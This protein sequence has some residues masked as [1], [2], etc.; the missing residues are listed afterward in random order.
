MAEIHE[1]ALVQWQPDDLAGRVAIVAA[2]GLGEGV[3][4]LPILLFVA[5]LRCRMRNDVV[6]AAVGT[7]R[8]GARGQRRLP[9][10]LL[11]R[12]LLRMKGIEK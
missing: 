8:R 12:F 11:D 2:R 4:E 10:G 7:D 3:G 9:V 1:R 5:P 6:G